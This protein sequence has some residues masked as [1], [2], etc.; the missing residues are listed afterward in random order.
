MKA[1]SEVPLQHSQMAHTTLTDTQAHNRKRLTY[2]T[3]CTLAP[4]RVSK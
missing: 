3:V 4:R 1:Y 2:I